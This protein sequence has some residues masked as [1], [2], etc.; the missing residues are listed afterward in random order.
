VEKALRLSS[1]IKTFLLSF[2]LFLFIAVPARG[3][4]VTL[5]WDPSPQPNLDYYVVYYG[6]SP[7]NYSMSETIHSD[8]TTYRVTGLAA[9][10]RYYFA[11]TA[12]DDEAYESFVSREVS[13]I[14]HG[15]GDEDGRDAEWG[16]TTGSLRNFNFVFDDA[17]DIP[18]LGD[19]SDIPGVNFPG[20]AGVGSPLNLQP[21]GV[22]FHPPVKVFIPCQGYTD[23]SDLDVY[24]YND[25]TLEWYLANDA[26]DPYTVQPDAID[27]MVP[28]S[29]VNHNGGNPS[30]IEIQ[31]YHFSGAQAGSSS[32]SS[33][34]SRN[35]G[36][37]GG[38]CFIGTVS[39]R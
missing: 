32:S 24:Y 14:K 34:A 33:S 25:V 31:V 1:P 13:W 10:T 20:M 11:V 38:G 23:V 16:I 30:T 29:R 21:S 9:N 12:V 8:T 22:Y 39:G 28:G 26:D 2:V 3:A 36:G 15:S 19:S 5:G 18:T 4:H 35:G 6:T 27:W 37:G 7:G 17:A